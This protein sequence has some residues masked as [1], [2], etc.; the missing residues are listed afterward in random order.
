[1]FSC[2][3]FCP[4]RGCNVDLCF[5]LF[6]FFFFY[7]CRITGYATFW[8]PLPISNINTYLQNNILVGLWRLQQYR[9]K[10]FVVDSRYLRKTWVI[11]VFYISTLKRLLQVVLFLPT[12]SVYTRFFFCTNFVRQV[13]T[14]IKL[15]HTKLKSY[16]HIIY[17]SSNLPTPGRVLREEA[18]LHSLPL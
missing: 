14:Y 2:I 10:K 5:H 17:S 3:F 1:M 4:Y 18:S 15:T 16:L 12:Y 8:K 9:R 6:L 11:N 7:R 13:G